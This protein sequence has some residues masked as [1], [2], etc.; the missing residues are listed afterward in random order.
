[1][2]VAV[3]EVGALGDA[4][5]AADLVEE[6]DRKAGFGETFDE[7]VACAGEAGAVVVFVEPDNNRQAVSCLLYTSPSPRD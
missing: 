7:A 3:V 1:V 5:A 6:E 2:R 4:G